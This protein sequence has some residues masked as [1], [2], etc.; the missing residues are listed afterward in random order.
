MWDKKTPSVNSH[1]SDQ[2]RRQGQLPSTSVTW[3]QFLSERPPGYRDSGFDAWGSTCLLRRH[4]TGANSH[5][6]GYPGP[7]S[8]TELR[9]VARAA[10]QRGRNLE[11]MLRRA[12]TCRLGKPVGSG[13][14]VRATEG[15]EGVSQ[16]SLP[17][18]I[19]EFEE[20]GGA[21][22]EWAGLSGIALVDISEEEGV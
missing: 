7:W 22:A 1:F 15:S 13:F 16:P 8:T 6:A 9:T 12:A 2:L 17:T 18:S 5:R 20:L 19:E 4:V 11:T 14:Q 3:E 10:R 21:F